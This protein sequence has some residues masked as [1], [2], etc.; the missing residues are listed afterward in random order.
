MNCRKRT[1]LEN[2]NDIH[3]KL[4]FNG[5]SQ[6]NKPPSKNV[7]IHE[8]FQIDAAAAH[9]HFPNN[10]ARYM[11]IECEITTTYRRSLHQ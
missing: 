8:I 6:Q 2:N 10:G 3:S 7:R 1:C 5:H 4:N 9:I 11:F